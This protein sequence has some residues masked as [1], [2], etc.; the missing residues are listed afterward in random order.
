[1]PLWSARTLLCTSIVILRDFKATFCAQPCVLEGGQGLYLLDITVP[2]CGLLE[3]QSWLSARGAIGM[4]LHAQPPFGS[5]C[6][7]RD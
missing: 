4:Q 6:S 5:G 7:G 3:Q 1:M 2:S